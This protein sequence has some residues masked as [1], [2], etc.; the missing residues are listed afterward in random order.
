MSNQITVIM[1]INSIKMEKDKDAKFMIESC[2]L[3]IDD[4][5]KVIKNS[6]LSLE[7]THKPPPSD[8][9]P[10]LVDQIAEDI[11]IQGKRSYAVDYGPGPNVVRDQYRPGTNAAGTTAG[12]IKQRT[13]AAIISDAATGRIFL[14]KLEE[15]V[16]K[17]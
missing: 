3:M 10:F 1:E 7:A 16:R 6:R 11:T 5:E 13:T 17:R 4:I 8:P 12:I 9:T 2:L 15:V 14:V